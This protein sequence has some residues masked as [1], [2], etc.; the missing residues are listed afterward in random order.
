MDPKNLYAVAIL[1]GIAG[2]LLLAKQYGRKIPKQ[3]SNAFTTDVTELARQGKLEA[4]AGREAEVERT[5][6]I[7]LRKNKNNPLLIGAPGVGKT[8]IVHGLAQLIVQNKV[9]DSLKNKKVLALDLTSL[10]SQ[11]KYR[12][13]LETKLRVLIDSLEKRAREVILFID[14]VHMLVR[15]GSAEGSVNLSDVFKPAMARG[16]LQI[17]GA[18]TWT[19]YAE[20]IRPDQALDRRF[21]PVLVDEP[22]PE[23]ALKILQTLRPEYEKF[24]GVKIT[25]QALEAA[26]K[27][28]DKQIKGR[29]LP[30]KAIDLIDEAAA[31]VSIESPQSTHKIPMGVVHTAA[32]N[33]KL[34]TVDVADIKDV[35]DQWMIHSKA[36]KSRDARFES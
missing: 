27:L 26:V 17:V 5:I 20:F 11:T 16:D 21:Q 15:V 9:P 18:T 6:H 36:E 34:G 19:E 2:I 32:K 23:Q 30:D 7:L 33:K 10:M 3:T 28:S 13:E 14:E 25:D 35:V 31:K 12:G 1:A 8:A 4:F 29:Y 22:T 24:H